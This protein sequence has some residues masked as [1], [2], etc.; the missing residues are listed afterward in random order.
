MNGYDVCRRLR[1]QAWGRDLLIIAQTG[2]GQNQDRQRSQDAGFDA[3]LTKPV[4]DEVL[5]ALLAGWQPGREV[6][7]SDAAP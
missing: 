4:D 7:S 3:H 1:E 5:L 2:W 6:T